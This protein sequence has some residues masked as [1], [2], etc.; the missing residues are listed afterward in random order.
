MAARTQDPDPIEGAPGVRHP[1]LSETMQEQWGDTRKGLLAK[2]ADLRESL[3]TLHA[4][5]EQRAIAWPD[6]LERFGLLRGRS[7]LCAC[8]RRVQM[9][10]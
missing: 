9:F 8:I 10:T 6:A 3:V 2:L 7:S 1:M 5:M 4:G